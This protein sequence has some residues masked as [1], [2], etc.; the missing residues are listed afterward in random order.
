MKSADTGSEFLQDRAPSGSF[1]V[2]RSFIIAFVETS[3]GCVVTTYFETFPDEQ[4]LLKRRFLF[5]L[6]GSENFGVF[7]IDN[8]IGAV[9][10]VSSEARDIRFGIGSVSLDVVV[11]L[12]LASTNFYTCFTDIKR[13]RG[14]RA[15]LFVD[16]FKFCFRRLGL[17]LAA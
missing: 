9:G 12:F 5:I 10:S 7:P 2:F 8:S 13:C 3:S 1:D 6:E 17:I 14:A 11:M 4:V 16:T 15:R